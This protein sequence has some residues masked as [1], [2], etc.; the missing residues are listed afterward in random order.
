MI[1]YG[2]YKDQRG[3]ILSDKESKIAK[4]V[5]VFIICWLVWSCLFLVSG[6]GNLIRLVVMETAG[7]L[8]FSAVQAF[9][10]IVGLIIFPIDGLVL[11]ISSY[12]QLKI[13]GIYFKQ[14]TSQENSFWVKFKAKA[15]R[16]TFSLLLGLI[17]FCA[18]FALGILW[19]Y[20]M[21][22]S[23][24]IIS[25]GIVTTY[26][27]G[28]IIFTTVPYI[29][30]KMNETEEERR[31]ARLKREAEHRQT[32]CV[33]LLTTAGMRFF[34]KYFNYLKSWNTSDIL[35]IIEEDYREQDK[36]QRIKAAQK[37]FQKNLQQAALIFIANSS[38]IDEATKSKAEDLLK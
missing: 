32:V 7:L 34:V 18:E 3:E 24:T 15:N 29:L 5:K 16:L 38:K 25:W 6:V 23:M 2:L 31:Q 28:V 20:V 4:A 8:R 11:S 22:D 26:S 36:W 10:V 12:R 14:K 9:E 19:V 17:L 13:N 1:Q 27:F 30:I 37:I 21:R 33:R 35:D